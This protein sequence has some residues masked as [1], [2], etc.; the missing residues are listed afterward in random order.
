MAAAA[1]RMRMGMTLLAT[2]MVIFAASV[3]QST[4]VYGVQSSQ[5]ST[6]H[7]VADD[8]RKSWL[9]AVVSRRKLR[10][11]DVRTDKKRFHYPQVMRSSFLFWFC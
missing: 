11:S 6:K 8:G 3:A 1:A 9:S 2:V 10:P 5:H 7:L 4:S